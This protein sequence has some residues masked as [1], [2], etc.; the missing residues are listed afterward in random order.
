MDRDICLLE[1][2]EFPTTQIMLMR[3]GICNWESRSMQPPLPSPVRPAEAQLN[4]FQPPNLDLPEP[5][6]SGELRASSVRNATRD[7]CFG[8]GNMAAAFLKVPFF[9]GLVLARE[10]EGKG[11]SFLRMLNWCGMIYPGQPK[12]NQKAITWNPSQMR[13]RQ[14]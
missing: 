8:R 6:T 7:T 14:C 3:W 5:G 4:P 11:Q 2:A 10:S 12:G 13:F 9:G 1:H